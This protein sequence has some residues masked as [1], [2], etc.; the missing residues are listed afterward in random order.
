MEILTIVVQV[1]LPLCAVV[2]ALQLMPAL[3]RW[4]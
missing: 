2:L 1:M 3:A 4:R